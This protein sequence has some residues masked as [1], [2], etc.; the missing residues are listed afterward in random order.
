MAEKWLTVAEACHALGMAERTLRRHITEGKITSKLEDGR[1]LVS[2]EVAEADM[3]NTESGMS[4][5]LLEQIRSENEQLRQQMEAKDKQI[6]ALQKDLT[7]TR[8]LLRTPVSDQI[9]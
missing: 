6:E 1:R 2:V 4:P 7:E 8:R 3:P 9:P 5:A